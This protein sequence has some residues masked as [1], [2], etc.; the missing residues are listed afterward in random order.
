MFIK[1]KLPQDFAFRVAYGQ[2][3]QGGFIR[4]EQAVF[5]IAYQYAA[6]Q[7]VKHS[8]KTED[9]LRSR[10]KEFPAL[11]KV[12]PVKFAERPPV[13]AAHANAAPKKSME[14]ASLC[15]SS[16]R[17]RHNFFLL[18]YLLKSIT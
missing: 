3:A 10:Y 4:H 2:E 5:F 14:G 18:S 15:E 17:V 8:I 16:R 7:R 13:K 11:L 12:E 1:D 6:W 9:F